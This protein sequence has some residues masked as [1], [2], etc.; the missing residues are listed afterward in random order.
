[1]HQGIS[2][3]KL[4]PISQHMVQMLQSGT[5]DQ[6]DQKCSNQDNKKDIFSVV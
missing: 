2:R 6:V 4:W 3:H 5:E 1:L